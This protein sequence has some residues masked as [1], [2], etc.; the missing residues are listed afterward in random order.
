MFQIDP[1]WLFVILS[2]IAGLF[3]L[4]RVRQDVARGKVTPRPR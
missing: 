4:V 1:G 2:G 3:F